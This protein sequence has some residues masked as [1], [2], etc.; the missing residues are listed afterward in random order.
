MSLKHHI[1][2][3]YLGRI[4]SM[5]C[6]PQTTWKPSSVRP[7][8]NPARRYP[9]DQ[10]QE[11]VAEISDA[12]LYFTDLAAEVVSSGAF[13]CHCRHIQGICSSRACEGLL[14]L[15]NPRGLLS[16]DTTP[17]VRSHALYEAGCSFSWAGL[18]RPVGVHTRTGFLDRDTPLGT[19]RGPISSTPLHVISLCTPRCYTEFGPVKSLG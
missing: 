5:I 2:A 18:D 13:T 19:H 16:E 3:P 6:S 7:R 17:E 12:E 4:C 8:G 1:H 14:P 9:L 15:K 11:V 10:L